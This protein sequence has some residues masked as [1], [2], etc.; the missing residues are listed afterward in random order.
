MKNF[1]TIIISI[2]LALF[3]SCSETR[4]E[5]KFMNELKQ[6]ISEKYD[7][8]KVEINIKSNN[9]LF[10]SLIDR[11]L[12]NH[13]SESKKQMSL[14]IGKLAQELRGDKEKIKAGEVKFV[15]EQKYGIAKTSKTESY[16]MY[17]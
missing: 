11:K 1:I 6:A 5:F 12:K 8:E 4:G 16:S 7:I 9:E 10:V 14:D 3:I 15:E 13:T 2:T 17:N